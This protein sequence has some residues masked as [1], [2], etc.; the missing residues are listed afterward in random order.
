MSDLMR[1]KG[2]T[3]DATVATSVNSSTRIDM[4]VSAGGTVQ[5][6]SGSI[7]TLSFYGC[8]RMGGTL[9]PLY[10]D[11]A[12]LTQALANGQACALPPETFGCK[13]IALVGNAAA[14]ADVG[15]ST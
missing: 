15:F 14:V 7:A 1:N 11:G 12:A 4:V 5:I 8:V 3:L 10:R 13:Q 2:E 9:V 6:T